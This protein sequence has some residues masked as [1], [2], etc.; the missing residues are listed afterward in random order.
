MGRARSFQGLAAGLAKIT[1]G[2]QDQMDRKAIA[3]A[4]KKGRIA[5]A[6]GT[7][8]LRDDDWTLSG[9]AFNDAALQ[10]FANQIDLNA[11]AKLAELETKFSIDP[12]GFASAAAGYKEGVVSEIALTDEALAAVFGQ[13]FDLRAASARG[14]ISKNY[15]T[16]YTGELKG[17]VVRLGDELGK[18][19]NRL[20]PDLFSDDP[21]VSTTA[22]GNYISIYER[23]KQA[24]MQ[25]GPDGQPVFTGEE[26]AKMEMA[27]ESDFLESAAKAYVDAT[28]DKTAAVFALQNGE[29]FIN[30]GIEDENGEM[31]SGTVNLTDGLDDE[32]RD[33]VLRYASQQENDAW[34]RSERSR[35]LRE[36]QDG[37][38][39]QVATTNFETAMT[40]RVE[41]LK[42][43][44]DLMD[45][46][47]MET[48]LTETGAQMNAAVS[49][50]QG[51][52]ESKAQLWADLQSARATAAL[53]LGEAARLAKQHQA[54]GIIDQDVNN[55]TSQVIRDPDAVS[56]AFGML[57]IAI[58]RN[59]GAFMSAEQEEEARAGGRQQILLSA[60]DG[61]FA[62]GN[63]DA[64]R[65]LL[66]V[67][68]MQETL[69]PA[70]QREYGNKIAEHDRAQ[71]KWIDDINKKIVAYE[72]VKGGPLTLTERLKVMG[73]SDGQG[74]QLSTKLRGEFRQSSGQ[75]VSMRDSFNRLTAATQEPSAAGD[76]ATI[77]NYMK[78][79]DPNSVVRESEFATAQ[80]SSAWLQEQEEIG[81]TVPRP[82]ASAI[83]QI[84]TGKRLSDAQ[85]ADFV[86]QARNMLNAQT[87]TQLQLETQYRDLAERQGVDPR[88]VVVDFLG[89]L[90]E[91][92]TAQGGQG[93]PT[94]TPSFTIDLMGRTVNKGE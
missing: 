30:V 72:Q 24:L 92:D 55:F 84:A 80:A 42:T 48:F 51:S 86:E 83:R 82:V 6:S 71:N 56:D 20:A 91:E 46:K 50:H 31:V 3:D 14:R 70:M 11:R 90:R 35:T 39:R 85:R 67:P 18:D 89:P 25:V 77:F 41:R 15:N 88:N 58:E 37:V 23:W 26:R 49:E 54:M 32:G 57:D 79:L 73:L 93:Q 87:K 65:E 13:Q 75:F 78:I 66:A 27:L 22:L 76:L 52:A 19:I 36:R 61:H 2:L 10:S 12:K 7:P 63:V 45:D 81:V 8:E 68:G 53:D 69:T 21:S 47:T 17:Q 62:R 59:A 94:G 29:A 16:F 74:D 43:E 9:E 4:K 5:G 60:L 1:D 34:M 28:D 64:A 40:L 44:G 38:K 33:R